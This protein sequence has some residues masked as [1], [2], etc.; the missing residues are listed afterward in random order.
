MGLPFSNYHKGS[1]GPGRGP[2]RAIAERRGRPM[3]EIKSSV[4]TKKASTSRAGSCGRERWRSP[5]LRAGPGPGGADRTGPLGRGR[6]L[7]CPGGAGCVRGR[8][9]VRGRH[10][11]KPCPAAQ[12]PTWAPRDSHARLQGELRALGFCGMAQSQ[13]LLA[14]MKS[15]R[16]RSRKEPGQLGLFLG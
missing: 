2:A 15:Q 9:P 6:L 16:V 5:E 8:T 7:V 11:R 10:Q 14:F 12:P 4:T 3:V 13:S 1:L